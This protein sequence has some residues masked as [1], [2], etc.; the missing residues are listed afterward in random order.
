VQVVLEL[1]EMVQQ[2]ALH[3]YQH[4]QLTVVLAVLLAT[5][6]GLR[7]QAMEALAA[8]VVGVVEQQ[9][10]LEMVVLTGQTVAIRHQLRLL[11]LV[12]LEVLLM[13]PLVMELHLLLEVLEVAE[14]VVVLVVF[15][16]VAAVLARAVLEVPQEV[17][18]EQILVAVAAQV[19][20]EALSLAVM[21]V[22]VA[23]GLFTYRSNAMPN[24]ALLNK[25]T[26]VDV[27]FCDE[28]I[29]APYLFPEYQVIEETEST[30][31]CYVGYT[32]TS[33]RFIS[34]QPYPSW[35][36]KNNNWVP[37][38]KVPA[39]GKIYNWNEENLNWIEVK[40]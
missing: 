18:L 32:Y 30:G 26:V 13:D 8:L 23:S 31:R 6:L 19:A 12:E 11:D 34:D 4:L 2:E 38:K 10:L 5:L 25:E 35:T 28:K 1:L 36:L 29:I 16:L 17:L 14:Q 22:L 33:G 40:N 27:F 24:F 39:D 3:P 21:V 9:A 15:T 7:V 37:P 20:E